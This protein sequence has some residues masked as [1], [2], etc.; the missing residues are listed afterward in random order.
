MLPKSLS[1]TIIVTALAACSTDE[2][3][4]PT[5]SDDATGSSEDA[6]DDG[7][8]VSATDTSGDGGSGDGDDTGPTGEVI[9]AGICPTPN[10]AFSAGCEPALPAC[11]ALDAS[12]P[13]ESFRGQFGSTSPDGECQ[14]DWPQP[15]LATCTEPLA[16][17]VPDLRGLWADEGHVERI[18]QCGNLIIII[19]D[20]YTH[21][22][23][24][25]GVP[26]DGVNDF[27]ADN[28]CAQPISVALSFEGQALQFVQNGQVVVT[29]TLEIAPDGSDELVWRFGPGLAEL[30]RMRR[31][32]SLS[33]VPPTASS[34][35]PG[36]K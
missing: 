16:E 35:L 18:E 30:A 25:T 5:T 21:G 10:P 9:P 13:A 33:E 22:G 3:T 20:N 34:G 29:R 24:A 26:E 15:W 23:F 14:S 1:S 28:T 11:A 4:G 27:R 7:S 6:T 8:S 32:C 2:S 19:G 17:G 12:V 31:F 36:G